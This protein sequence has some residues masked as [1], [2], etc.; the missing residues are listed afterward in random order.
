MPDGVVFSAVQQANLSLAAWPKK[1]CI[2]RRLAHNQHSL[3]EYI[4]RNSRRLSRHIAPIIS[5][6]ETSDMISRDPSDETLT[7]M[8]AGRGEL[9]KAGQAVEVP[10]FTPGCSTTPQELH[11]EGVSICSSQRELAKRSVAIPG[12]QVL[13]LRAPVTLVRYKTSFDQ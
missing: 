8:T 4:H 13:L 10:N 1:A 11:A 6:L 9:Y 5:G 3:A 12:W 2:G 7:G